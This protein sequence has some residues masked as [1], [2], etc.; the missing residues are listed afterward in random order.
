MIMMTAQA[1][2]MSTVMDS[3]GQVIRVIFEV[4]IGLARV[5]VQPGEPLLELAAQVAPLPGLE[6]VGIMGYEGH[7][8]TIPDMAEKKEK[9]GL[10]LEVLVDCARSMKEAGFCCD[11]V[12]CGGTGSYAFSCSHPGITEMER[13]PGV[14]WPRGRRQG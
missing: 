9:I 13:P 2:P 3:E 11:I 1:I 14:R 10:A 4:D 5:G 8:L 12:S 6:V 7:L